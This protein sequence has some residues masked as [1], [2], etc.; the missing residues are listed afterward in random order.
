MVAGR[1]AELVGW[2]GDSDNQSEEDL[3]LG[4]KSGSFRVGL[5]GSPELNSFPTTRKKNWYGGSL[6]LSMTIS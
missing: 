5:S 2:N 3:C 6:R 1:G 4:D